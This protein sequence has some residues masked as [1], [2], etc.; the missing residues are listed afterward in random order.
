LRFT[1]R[2]QPVL[3]AV[4]TAAEELTTCQ[5]AADGLRTGQQR[6]DLGDGTRR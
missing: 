2:A 5:E 3:V 4:G 6:G 1:G